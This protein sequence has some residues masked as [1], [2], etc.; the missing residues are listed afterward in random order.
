MIINNSLE[1]ILKKTVNVLEDS[2]KDI[3]TIGESARK[4]YDNIRT[5]LDLIKEEI[6]GVIDEVDK[7]EKKNRQARLRLMEVSRDFYNYTEND[8]KA[9]Y[10]EAEESSIEIAVLREKEGQL[11][12]R[13][14]ELENRL[15]NLEKTVKKAEH[16]VSRVSIIRDFLMGEL[17][18][19]SDEFDDLRQKNNLAIKIIQAQEEERRRLAREIHDGPAQSIA[20][21]VFRVELTEKL[22]DKDI[23]KAKDELEELK[24]LIRLSMQDVRKIIYNLRPMSLDDLGLVPTL[25]RYIN[26]FT[27]ETGI[28]IEFEVLGSQHRLSNTHEV[29]VFR[30]IQEALNNMFKHAEAANGKVRLEY[31]E[32]SINLLISDDGVGFNCSEV[33]EDKYGLISMEERCSLLGGNINI[34]SE[35][36]KGTIIK[37]LLPIKRSDELNDNSSINS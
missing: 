34:K 13:R 12:S 24:R 10:K 21:L 5:E 6:N 35:H 31:G 8:I 16:L 22:M 4:E 29:T 20:N 1:E 28:M 2:K 18:N 37:I 26:K 17:T 25:K 14:Q 33:D 27:R 30:L 23:K 7:L 32:D 9:A 36:S 3:F 19:L 11:R 15:I